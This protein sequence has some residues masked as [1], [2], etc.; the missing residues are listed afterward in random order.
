MEI[1]VLQEADAPA[2]WKVRLEAL[3]TEPL[4]FGKSVEEH[5][6]TPVSTIAERFRSPSGNNFT[7]GAFLEGVLV[8]TATFV[9]EADLKSRH[10]GHVYGVYVSSS[11]RRKGIGRE[12]LIRLLNTV[13]EDATIEQVLL[14]VGSTQTAARD[15]YL[16][17]GFEPFGTEPRA[18]KIGAAYI[19]ETHLILKIR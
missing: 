1:R 14:A 3:Q 16:S 7:M 9:R 17:L 11:Q 6:A 12:L 8:G 15:L 2:W 18:L 19:D 10:K 13:K 4:A 5:Q